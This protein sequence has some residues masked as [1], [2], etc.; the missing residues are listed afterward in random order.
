MLSLNQRVGIAI[1]L[2]FLLGCSNDEPV[3]SNNGSGTSEVYFTINTATDLDTSESDDWVLLYNST[4]MLLGVQPYEAGDRLVFETNALEALTDELIVT[5]FRSSTGGGSTNH[6][7]TS[8]PNIAKGSIWN[9]KTTDDSFGGLPTG[10]DLGE[11]N[12]SID[13][14]PGE[15]I[16]SNISSQLG[17]LGGSVSSTTINNTSTLETTFNVF[18]NA[19]RHLISIVDGNRDTRFTFVDN[20]PQGGSLNLDYSTFSDFDI[21]VP[22]SIP[23]TGDFLATVRAFTSDQQLFLRDGFT[24][25]DILPSEGRSFERPFQLGYLTEFENYITTFNYWPESGYIYFYSKYGERPDGITIPSDASLEL[26]DESLFNFRFSTNLPYIRRQSQW[27]NSSGRAG[28]DFVLTRWTVDTGDAENLP[29][30]EI[31]MEIQERYP[32]IDLDVLEYTVTRFFTDFES[33]RDFIERN[34]VSETRS[35]GLISSEAYHFTR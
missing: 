7:F 35:S 33:Y 13:N 25:T 24:L 31:P 2:L 9:F 11:F 8:Y 22:V 5:R 1:A 3:T 12:I 26:I 6:T 10:A 4:G 17:R 16:T 14:I 20:L 21:Q 23:D 29:P 27:F 32:E 28:V 34:F 18:E 15:P 30:M 19:E